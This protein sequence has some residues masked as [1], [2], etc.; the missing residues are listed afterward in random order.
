MKFH[1]S[2]IET[3]SRLDLPGTHPRSNPT[4]NL[5]SRVWDRLV[6][7]ITSFR[8]EER[9]RTVRQCLKSEISSK[10]LIWIRQR[11]TAKYLLCVINNKTSQLLYQLPLLLQ[12][13]SSL[14]SRYS[15]I[16][17]ERVERNESYQ[18]SLQLRQMVLPLL[19]LRQLR[20]RNHPKW[21]L[22]CTK[23]LKPTQT[24]IVYNPTTNRGTTI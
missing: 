17:Q 13:F 20:V 8:T 7:L 11:L 2:I 6:S 23:F 22:S 10:R 15:R 5:N 21:D 12:T 3:V 19:L 4:R 1:F 18:C 14:S 9:P 24:I 16:P